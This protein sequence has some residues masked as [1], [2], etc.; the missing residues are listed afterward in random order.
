MLA[1]V[2][3][4]QQL[5]CQVGERVVCDRR[6]TVARATRFAAGVCDITLEGG[7]L[8]YV[9]EFLVGLQVALKK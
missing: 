8:I 4:M 9:L 2:T 7:V 6:S 1:A 5:A 3:N